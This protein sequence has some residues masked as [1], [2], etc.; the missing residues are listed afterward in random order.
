[1]FDVPDD[2]W[3]HYVGVE[4]RGQVVC[5]RCWH[6]L[7]DVIDG[8]AYQAQHPE[9]RRALPLWSELWIASV[10]GRPRRPSTRWRN[11]PQV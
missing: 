10:T 11:S 8:G 2:V 1:L 7:T 4:Q 3:L 5:I 9:H 6:W